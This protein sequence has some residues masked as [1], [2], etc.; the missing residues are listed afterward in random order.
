MQRSNYRSSVQCTENKEEEEE[1][2]RMI[3]SREALHAV[4]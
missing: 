1:D 3:F 4:S 2:T